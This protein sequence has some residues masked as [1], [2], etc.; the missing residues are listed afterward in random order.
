MKEVRIFTFQEQKHNRDFTKSLQSKFKKEAKSLGVEAESSQ[1]L[2]NLSYLS[3]YSGFCFFVASIFCSRFL[4]DN[5]ML[6][7]KGGD[8]S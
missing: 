8:R 2:Q 5:G 4:A 3:I 7:N 6:L 1:R